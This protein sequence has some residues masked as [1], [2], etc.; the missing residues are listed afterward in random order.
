MDIKEQTKH[1]I[2]FSNLKL[3]EICA[4]IEEQIKRADSKLLSL[5]IE[6]DIELVELRDQLEEIYDKLDSVKPLTVE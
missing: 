5:P 2:Y 6:G 3:A 4:N 1:C